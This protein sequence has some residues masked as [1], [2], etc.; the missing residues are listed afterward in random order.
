LNGE[1]GRSTKYKLISF[2]AQKLPII[3]IAIGKKI[4][5]TKFARIFFYLPEYNKN[6]IKV[7]RFDIMIGFK[8]RSCVNESHKRK[9]VHH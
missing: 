9:G 4:K 5:Q 6:K 3:C 1:G 7:Y 8:K 2:V